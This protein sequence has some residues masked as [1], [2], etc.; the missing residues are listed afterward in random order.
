[1]E[2]VESLAEAAEIGISGKEIPEVEPMLL[3]LD[4]LAWHGPEYSKRNRERVRESFVAILDYLKSFYSKEKGSLDNLDIQRGIQAVMLLTAEAAQKMD[5]YDLYEGGGREESVTQL[6]EYQELEQFYQT[7]MA[8]KSRHYVVLKEGWQNLWKPLAMG[9]ILLDDPYHLTW[10]SVCRDTNYELFLIRREDGT[11]FFSEELL[12]HLRLVGA[13]DTFFTE[14][15]G[16]DLFS[17]LQEI[18]ER[19]LHESARQIIQ[20]LKGDL[21]EYFNEALRY[22]DRPL[23][24]ALNRAIMALMLAANPRHLEERRNKRCSHY[25][26]DFHYYLRMALTSEEYVGWD[27]TIP[28]S[29][30]SSSNYSSAFFK[31]LVNMV[32]GLV[33]AFYLRQGDVQEIGLFLE[34][35]I[36]EGA[37]GIY[38]EASTKSPESTWHAVSDEYTQ[39]VWALKRHPNGPLLKAIQVLSA[40]E[41]GEMLW[42]FDPLIQQNIPSSMYSLDYQGK[43]VR[44]IRMPFPTRQESIKEATIAEEFKAFIQGM[45]A[46]G[47]PQ[48]HLMILLEDGESSL[49]K[50]RYEALLQFKKGQDYANEGLLLIHLPKTGDFYT[51]SGVYATLD[52]PG[53]FIDELC[54]RAL[55]FSLKTHFVEVKEMAE[56]IYRQFFGEKNL[57]TRKNRMDF[58]EIFDNYCILKCLEVYQPDTISFNCKDGLDTGVAASAGFYVFFQKMQGKNE[59]N[60][61]LW[62]EGLYAPS[63]LL[64]HRLILPEP[65]DRILSALNVIN[66]N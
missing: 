30:L 8:Q 49:S 63:L 66:L 31:T 2:A 28:I 44:C 55:K 29:K 51:Q 33:S 65:L 27:K 53:P 45:N 61:T 37:K 16:D 42:G 54:R 18:Q 57:L 11:P 21:E 62:Q 41:E 3:N 6:K 22:K 46:E 34:R 43:E 10:H 24:S 38:R 13:F 39:M 23:V 5:R 58:I 9:N 19:D 32:Y 40:L 1:M 25:F 64:R 15:S 48:H 35:L 12:R 7:K 36:E 26:S 20:E 59:M 4:I 56:G 47:H 14:I 60:L 17:K 50:A 52:E